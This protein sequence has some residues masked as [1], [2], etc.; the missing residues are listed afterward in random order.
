MLELDCL[1][2]MCPV[3]LLKAQKEA[4]SLPSGE[5]LKII[6]DHS[7]VHQNVITYFKKKKFLIKED[8]VLNGVWEIF[9]TKP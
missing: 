3:P 1:G 8:E 2:E 7:C 9:L 6:T 5:T 4:Q